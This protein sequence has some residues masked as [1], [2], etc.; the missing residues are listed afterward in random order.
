MGGEKTRQKKNAILNVGERFEVTGRKES[1]R[2]SQ[3]RAPTGVKNRRVLVSDLHRER[4]ASKRGASE[5][6]E[7]KKNP[8]NEMDRPPPAKCKGRR[9]RENK[10]RNLLNR[11]DTLNQGP[12]GERGQKR[13][14]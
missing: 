12:K 7:L 10:D 8:S 3:E 13:G 5:R 1:K 14:G 6:G 9:T 11:E 4:N 2:A